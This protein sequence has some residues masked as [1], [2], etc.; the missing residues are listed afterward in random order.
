MGRNGMTL[1]ERL[2]LVEQRRTHDLE[3]MD[4]LSQEIVRLRTDAVQCEGQIALLKELL[5]H[6]S[7][8]SGTPSLS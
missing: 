4:L 6:E 8:S 7:L 3:Q 1:K 5:S 2:D